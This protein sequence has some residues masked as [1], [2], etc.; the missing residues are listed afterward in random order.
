M[1]RIIRLSLILLAF[2]V[3]GGQWMMLQSVAWVN[4]V[5]DYSQET[6]L[7]K[8]LSQTFDGQHPCELCRFIQ[9]TKTSE[10]NHSKTATTAPIKASLLFFIVFAAL[11]ITL[12]RVGKIYFVS[13]IWSNRGQVPLYQPPELV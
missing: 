6:S 8:A 2:W 10:D 13:S 11:T 12:I 4:M 3:T 5:R 7:T 1:S 9:S